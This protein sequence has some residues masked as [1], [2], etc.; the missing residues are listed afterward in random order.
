MEK[1]KEVFDYKALKKK[2]IE[3]FRSGKNLFGKGR[4]L[5]AHA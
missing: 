1:K 5:C 2:T 4:R 3:Q